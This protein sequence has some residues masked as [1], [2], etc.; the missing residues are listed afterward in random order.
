VYIYIYKFQINSRLKT[1]MFHRIFLSSAIFLVPFG[2][3]TAF[4]DLEI[5]QDLLRT[6]VCLFYCF[7]FIYLL[8]LVTCARLSWPHSAIQCTSNSLIV[9]YRVV[10]R[11]CWLF[12]TA[13]AVY[14]WWTNYSCYVETPEVTP[15]D[16]ALCKADQQY[17]H[18]I[19][20]STDC[21]DVHCR[22]VYTAVDS[23]RSDTAPDP[24]W[25]W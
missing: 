22:L 18:A 8:F 19:P 1:H 4:T 9:S 24:Q 6:G 11:W 12:I 25:H 2:Q 15:I 23:L 5:G 16:G 3:H 10:F 7:F 14:S 20:W 21:A 13:S 17:Q